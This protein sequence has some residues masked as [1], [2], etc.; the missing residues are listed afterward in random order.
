MADAVRF[1]ELNAHTHSR[2]LTLSLTHSLTH[3]HTHSLTHSLTHSF[4]HTHTQ[5]LTHSFTHSAM[6][7]RSTTSICAGS[8]RLLISSSNNDR[9]PRCR[10][11]ASHRAPHPLTHPSDLATPPPLLKIETINSF[12]LS[13]ELNK[14]QCKHPPASCSFTNTHTQEEKERE[15]AL[16]CTAYH[17]SVCISCDLRRPRMLR[18]YTTCSTF[19]RS[20]LRESNLTCHKNKANQT[21]RKKCQQKKT[22]GIA[23]RMCAR[24]TPAF[25]S[26]PYCPWTHLRRRPSFLRLRS[27]KPS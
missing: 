20:Y 12:L 21:K 8:T 11:P 13:L 27:L 1:F 6:L 19:F 15:C 9:H 17:Q 26:S 10:C 22:A 4:T 14:S 2:T 24:T 25:P 5:S 3:A 7:C 16:S 23:T 18:S